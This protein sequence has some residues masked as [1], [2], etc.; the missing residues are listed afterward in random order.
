MKYRITLLAAL[1]VFATTTASAQYSETNNLFYFAQRA[2]QSNM[3]NPSFFPGTL[4][5]QLPS[6]NS[7]QLGLPLA[8]GDIV[9]YDAEQDVN[10]IDLNSTLDALDQNS[11]F[12]LGMDINLLGTGL[13]IAG[14]FVDANMQLRTNMGFDLGGGIINTV[15]KGNVGD[16]GEPIPEMTL[17]DGQLFNLQ[18]YMETSVGAGMHI[19]LTGLTVGA[20][21]KLLSG[22]VNLNTENTH[23][24]FETEEDYNSV[25]A[26]VY[27]EIRGASAL[28]IDTSMGFSM[29]YL[30]SLWTNRTDLFSTFYDLNNGNNGVAFDLGAKYDLGPLTVSASIN[31]LS[32]GI[33]WQSNL[34]AL[35]PKG[36]QGTIE[37]DGMDIANLLD[38]GSINVDSVTAYLN[39]QING[40]M[41]QMQFDSGDFYYNIPT[42]LNLAAT[43]NLGILKAGILFHG[44]WDR[45]LLKTPQTISS[46]ND[47]S[48]DLGDDGIEGL[49][50]TFRSNTTVSVG[51]NLINWIEVIA[52]SSFV[53][54]GSSKI[55]FDNFLN[56]GLGIIV[57]PA[58][59]F[60]FYAMMDYASSMYFTQMKAFNF[61]FGFNMVFGSSTK[62]RIL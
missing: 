10:V 22:I 23:V 17:L 8:I 61:K 6:L 20:H 52:G 55:A 36:G 24:S 16:N 18:M 28:P 7:I 37:F 15:L 35:V 62:K 14:I 25:R 29:D 19:P 49:K 58:T 5:L 46:I 48:I 13:K 9:H 45:G 31:D 43:F 2:P 53:Y 54:D 50:N 51:V 59:L 39:D 60:Q 33:H 12:R 56:P 30:K 34:V 44:Q 3:L 40:M 47:F 26:N 21:V 27:Y 32:T 11:Q 1:F 42:K 4:Y 41:P 57:S 38:G